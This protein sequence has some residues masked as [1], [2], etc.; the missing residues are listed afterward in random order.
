[1]DNKNF[2]EKETIIQQPSDKEIE[3]FLNVNAE[4]GLNEVVIDVMSDM[5]I[6][7]YLI[8]ETNS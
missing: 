4:K 3:E 2:I 5:E 8:D 6:R 1:M 7:E